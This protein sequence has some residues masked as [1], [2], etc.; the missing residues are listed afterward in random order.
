[1]R[2]LIALIISLP[3]LCSCDE[4]TSNDWSFVSKQVQNYAKDNKGHIVLPSWPS[5]SVKWKRWI[6][7][8]PTNDISQD[9]LVKHT[10]DLFGAVSSVE[11]G[12]FSKHGKKDPIL[13]ESDDK[14]PNWASGGAPV[15]ESSFD[16]GQ[17]ISARI[18]T[19]AVCKDPENGNY[20]P[21]KT[22]NVSEKKNLFIVIDLMVIK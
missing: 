11:N 18:V 1:M 9:T 4:E 21:L 7:V 12:A 17:N 19:S 16:S 5:S 22:E 8:I 14:T 15:W 20:I 13:K 10:D 2:L 6:I 3:F